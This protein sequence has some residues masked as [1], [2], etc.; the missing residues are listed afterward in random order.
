MIFIPLLVHQFL[1]L[2][3]LPVYTPS[4]AANGHPTYYIYFFINMFYFSKIYTVNPYLHNLLYMF[5]NGIFAG[6]IAVF[7][8]ALSFFKKINRYAVIILPTIFYF[9]VNYIGAVLNTSTN[10]SIGYYLIITSNV[11]GLNYKFFAFSVISLIIISIITIYF[12]YSRDE[13]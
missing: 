6:A 9:V 10:L 5:L 2:I 13:I 8:Y 3:L 7:S 4:E 1:C 11:K 12:N